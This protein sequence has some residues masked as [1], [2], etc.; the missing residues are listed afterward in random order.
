MHSPDVVSLGCSPGSCKVSPNVGESSRD[1]LR[2]VSRVFG[3]SSLSDA[4]EASGIAPVV[5]TR[6]SLKQRDTPGEILGH[7]VDVRRRIADKLREKIGLENRL[8]CERLASERGFEA[9]FLT[10]TRRVGSGWRQG[11]V[12]E[13]MR[14]LRRWYRRLF[15]GCGLPYQWVSEMQMKRLASG[16]D[17]LDCVHHH[18]LVFLPRG[19]R[20]P[21]VGPVD[22]AERPGLGWWPHGFV[23]V[24][25]GVRN[26]AAYMAKYLSKLDSESVAA[27]P[28]GCR[29]YGSGGLT[30]LERMTSRWW[31]LPSYVR[32]HFGDMVADV[33]RR[34]GGGFLSRVTGNWLASQWRVSWCWW[35]WDGRPVVQVVRDVCGPLPRSF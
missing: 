19:L 6:Q 18:V 24:R 22:N 1:Y 12:K 17:P 20:L 14:C 30:E 7:W 31:S 21:E 33:R 2:D 15:P 10:L 11:D 28:A 25:R 32:E 29:K 35:L 8:I 23:D 27:M 5:E 26:P 34:V 13:F 3:L 16:G 9:V 4:L